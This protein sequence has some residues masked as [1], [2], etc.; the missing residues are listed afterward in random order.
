VIGPR[1]GVLVWADA[2]SDLVVV[3]SLSFLVDVAGRNGRML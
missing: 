3:M 2:D 1:G